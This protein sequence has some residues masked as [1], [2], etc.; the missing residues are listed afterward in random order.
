MGDRF[1]THPLAQGVLELGLLDED[2]VLGRFG[3]V[4]M[5]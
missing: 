2:V 4:G 3:A 5:G 1:F